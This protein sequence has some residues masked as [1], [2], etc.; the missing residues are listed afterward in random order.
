MSP[1][2]GSCKKLP[3]CVYIC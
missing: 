1:Q 2:D 3:Y